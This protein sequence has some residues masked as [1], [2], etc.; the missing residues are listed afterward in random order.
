LVEAPGEASLLV[1]AYLINLSDHI[2]E[3]QEQRGKDDAQKLHRVPGLQMI[4]C[5]H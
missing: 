1:L 4:L 3:G 2:A 5:D